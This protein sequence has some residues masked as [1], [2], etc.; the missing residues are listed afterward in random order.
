MIIDCPACGAGLMFDPE[1]GKMKCEAC[2]S[3]FETYE[4][5]DDFQARGEKE[6]QREF[7]KKDNGSLKLSGEAVEESGLKLSGDAVKES[8]LKLSDSNVN[9]SGLK[10]SGTPGTSGMAGAAELDNYQFATDSMDN[11]ASGKSSAPSFN[12]YSDFDHPVYDHTDTYGQDDYDDTG[13]PDDTMECNIYTCTSCG[14]E[15]AINDNEAS[16]FCSFCGQPTVVFSR[17]ASQKKP[18]YIIPFSVTKDRAISLIRERLNNGF[19][20]P[21][22][23]KNFEIERVRGIYIP[24]WLYDIYY[25]DKQYL[26]GT[27]GSGKNS[28]TYY[29]FREADCDFTMLSLDASRQLNDE[30][31]Q[32]LE[33]YNT[34]G[35]K[36]FSLEY[37]SGF[38]ADCYDMKTSQL[39]GL[40]LSRAQELFNSEVERTINAHSISIIRNDPEFRIKATHYAMFPAWFL[41]FRYEN[42]PYTLLV[43]GQ[44]E[45]IIGGIP[46]DRAKVSASF[47]I[48]AA[49]LTILATII[50]FIFLTSPDDDNG[51]MVTTAIVLSIVALI[52][53]VNNLKKVKEST[54]LSGL[55]ETNRFV[56]D[57][58]TQ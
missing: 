27:V 20:V 51:K 18:K 10:L 26:K 13:D 12:P 5:E 58:G 42:I 36:E 55:S 57:R 54:K 2:G 11:T 53:G 28:H 24:F 35:I 34:G 46:Y 39:D 37:L 22:E 40:A 15:V 19:Y 32:R 29:Y 4:L 25:H 23:I 1:S 52:A 47:G 45:K 50:T 7:A 33:P 38:Y 14:A 9:E 30:T 16:T 31:S 44:T 41:T 8:G 6:L 17:I 3:L 56:K 49:I 43:N 48:L 21:N